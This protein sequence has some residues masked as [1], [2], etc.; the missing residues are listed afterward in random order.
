[1]DEETFWS[2]INLINHK[3]RIPTNAVE[4]LVDALSKL[5][6]D[7]IRAFDDV[8]SAKLYLLDTKK[9]ARNIGPRRYKLPDGGGFSADGFLYAR[10]YAVAKGRKYYEDALADPEKMPKG[11]DFEALLSC[12]WR[13][14]EASND[15]EYDRDTEFNFE[16]FSNQEGWPQPKKSKS[17]TSG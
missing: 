3:K 12:G 4:P 14:F 6:A 11:R 5:P 7:E 13:A 1:M 17:K 16:T 10:L 15:E 8:L 9:H 2:L